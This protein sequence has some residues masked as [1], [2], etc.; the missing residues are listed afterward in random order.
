[1]ISQVLTEDPTELLSVR[2]DIDAELA[3]VCEKAMN[4]DLDA[5]YGS[6]KEFA[7]ALGKYLQSSAGDK[8]LGEPTKTAKVTVSQIQL[9]EQSKLAKTMCESGQFVAAV[10]ILKQIISNP[11]AKGSKMHQWAEAM[12]PKVEAQIANQAQPKPKVVATAA[13][14][15][16]AADNL[17][18]DLPAL[19]ATAA[20]AAGTAPYRRPG[21]K[22]SKTK[23]GRPIA[24][25]SAVAA[26]VLLI[27]GGGAACFFFMGAKETPA[28]ANDPSATTPASTNATTALPD[29]RPIK[30][31]SG[32]GRPFTKD[33]VFAAEL[34]DLFDN[35]RDHQL[36]S[37]EIP[38]PVYGG[39]M[40]ADA[41]QDEWLSKPELASLDRSDF[42]KDLDQLPRPPTDARPPRFGDLSEF[43]KDADG[44]IELSGIHG[45]RR[46]ALERA[47]TDSNGVLDQNEIAIL[48]QREGQ[49]RRP[50]GPGRGGPGS[51]GP[52]RGEPPGDR[53]FRPGGRPGN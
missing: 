19:P 31:K 22:K 51:G 17:F 38:P 36:D 9:T 27:V 50:G 43:D 4:K 41:N 14:K 33:P 32:Q 37:T 13:T 49:R 53:P 18:A 11:D 2:S 34:L 42:P 7:T 1:M 12:L 5:R 40:A 45:P 48:R 44:Q 21:R 52:N 10:S 15:L 47:D 35:N 6:M 23:S 24:L 3:M 46:L 39:M 30:P 29:D 25:I 26:V 20:T 8:R 16:A 28:T